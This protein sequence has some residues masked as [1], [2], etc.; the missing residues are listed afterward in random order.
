MLKDLLGETLQGMLEADDKIGMNWKKRLE[1]AWENGCA[2]AQRYR[3]SHSDLLV[4]VHYKD[5]DGFALGEWIVYNR[6]RYLSGNLPSDRVERLEALGMVWDTGS[7]L[8]EKSYAAAV[9]YYLE[10]HTLKIPV[11]YVTPDGMALGVWLGSQRA[12]YKEGVLTDAQIE[13]LEALGVDWTNRNDRKWQ[14]AYEAAVKYHAAHGNLDVPTEYIDE[15]GILLGKWVS[16]QRY[17]WQNPE[18]S[19]ARVTLER[20]ALLDELGMNW[21]KTDSWQHRYELAVEYK[22][23]TA[24][25]PFRPS[26]GRR[27]ASGW[28]AGCP[29]RSR[30]CGR[31]KSSPPSA[32]RP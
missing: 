30:C 5:K 16:R 10:N 28:A 12:A 29:V 19:S 15:D 17:A 2:S 18:R 4:P 25:W 7:I 9:Q 31:A 3:G 22:R 6:Q 11:K 8:W 32:A 24:V 13:K 27:T 14:T 1:L 21:E 20:K 23:S 26:T